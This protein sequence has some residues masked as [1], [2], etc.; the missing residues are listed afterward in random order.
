MFLNG[1]DN[2]VPGTFYTNMAFTFTDIQ[3]IYV[4]FTMIRKR[5]FA[6]QGKAIEEVAMAVFLLPDI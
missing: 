3:Q 5:L 2:W 6:K 4:A 1:F